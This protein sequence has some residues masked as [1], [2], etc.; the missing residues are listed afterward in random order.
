MR[1]DITF[2]ESG[3][4][5]VNGRGDL[6]T[7]LA[8]LLQ[9]AAESANSASASFYLLDARKNVLRPVVT[10]GLPPAY[11]EACGSIAVGDQCCGR[12]VQYRKPWIV[13]DMLNDPL[14]ASAKAAALMSPIRAAFSVPV[15]GE[16]GDC[17]GSLA[18]H[19]AESYTATREQIERNE[20]WAT[21]IAHTLSSYRISE[22]AG[23]RVQSA[24]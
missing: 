8:E 20:T 22:S 11:V 17:F 15:I 6:K 13:S 5:L 4:R 1:K 10:Y 3:L 23:Q 14:F 2:F 7:A 16:D 12:A 9:L 19:Y 21:M 24:D 18:C